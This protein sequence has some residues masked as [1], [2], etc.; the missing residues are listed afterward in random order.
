VRARGRRPALPRC[1]ASTVSGVRTVAAFGE[2]PADRVRT[3]CG[4][5][6][7]TTRA[8]QAG[9]LRLPGLLVLLRQVAAR[10]VPDQT[11]VASGPH[12]GEAASHQTGTA[13]A[14][15]PADSAASEMAGAGDPRLLQLPRG[16]D[17][18][19]RARELPCRDR[20]GLVA[21]AAPPRT[22]TPAG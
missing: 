1:P 11:Q 6:P 16:A 15:A 9:D 5:K 22:P 13:A 3:L 10:Q 17:E 20:Q 18:P 7:Q 4:S 8:R 2:D 21:A 14:Y 12:A 19:S